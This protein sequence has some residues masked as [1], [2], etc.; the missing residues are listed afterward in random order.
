[1]PEGSTGH[2]LVA[3]VVE[4]SDQSIVLDFDIARIVRLVLSND[5][6][7]DVLQLVEQLFQLIELAFDFLYSSH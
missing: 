4:P 1:M 7:V 3:E 5:G 2:L 6:L